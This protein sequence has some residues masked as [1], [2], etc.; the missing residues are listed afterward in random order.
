MIPF[1]LGLACTTTSAPGAVETPIEADGEP[2]VL[3]DPGVC[4]DY[5]TYYYGVDLPTTRRG[6]YALRPC[7]RTAWLGAPMLEPADL[8]G[9]GSAINMAVLRVDASDTAHHFLVRVELT[10]REDGVAV[11]E[12]VASASQEW[13]DQ[14]LDVFVSHGAGEDL[15]G[16]GVADWLL[17]GVGSPGDDP[18]MWSIEPDWIGDQKSTLSDA[19]KL[20]FSPYPVGDVTGDGIRDIAR[21]LDWTTSPEGD[22]SLAIADLP[23]T[24]VSVDSAWSTT[25]GGGIRA[26]NNRFY[27]SPVLQGSF[28]HNGDGVSDVVAA[29]AVLSTQSKGVI[30]VFDGPIL[31]SRGAEDADA[32]VSRI[33]G[34]SGESKGDDCVGDDVRSGGDLNQ[35]GYDDLVVSSSCSSVDGDPLVGMLLV[36]PGPL[37][38]SVDLEGV[39]IAAILGEGDHALFPD[40]VTTKGD[41]DGDGWLDIFASQEVDPTGSGHAPNE[42]PGLRLFHGPLEG[43][44]EWLDGVQI[45]DR[46][47]TDWWEVSD[48]LIVDQDLDGDGLHDVVMTEEYAW[49]DDP[50]VEYGSRIGDAINIWFSSQSSEWPRPWAP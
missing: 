2:R 39:S 30:R 21:R 49:R 11:F 5:D 45:K 46:W 33:I 16:D 40:T 7:S 43:T 44:Y 12:E 17:V 23:D 6:D 20:D 50:E 35:D 37:L 18:A 34:S 38:G 9:Q 47:Y 8:S 19:T 13:Q 29:D 4:K 10:G 31:S 28:D 42:Y 48:Y 1:I 22:S 32:R 26:S 41:V 27:R 25:V 3:P 14:Q 36:V 15:D 24:F